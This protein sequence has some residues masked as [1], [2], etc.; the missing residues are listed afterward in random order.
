M[1]ANGVDQIKMGQVRLELALVAVTKCLTK[2]YLKKEGDK[3]QYIVK[4]SGG[5]WVD[6]LCSQQPESKQK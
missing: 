5:S 3:G 1:I 6:R 2:S 4:G